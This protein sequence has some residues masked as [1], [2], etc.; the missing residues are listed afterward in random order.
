[1]KEL[2]P[3]GLDLDARK[4][5]RAKI[6]GHQ[7]E[8]CALGGGLNLMVPDKH[9][10][11]IERFKEFLDLSRDIGSGI[12]TTES[13]SPP[14]NVSIDEAWDLFMRGIREIALHAQK[15]GT[16][17]AVELGPGCLID[18]PDKFLKLAEG[19]K[20]PNLKVNY[21]PG[22]VIMAGLD[23]IEGLR[24]LR[25]FVV[26]TH[27]KDAVYSPGGKYSEVALGTG[28]LDLPRYIKELRAI[29]YD[30]YLTIE[31]ETG[32]DPVGDVRRAVGLLRELL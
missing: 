23:P 32:P 13:K 27:M 15:T 2:A 12:V 22:N 5:L 29:G 8:I 21:D 20:S 25:E 31:R 19:V 30:G 1:M 11:N 10:E 18:T 7:M 28:A 9:R 16:Y 26:H 24:T 3:E 4:S 6:E 14:A 17:F